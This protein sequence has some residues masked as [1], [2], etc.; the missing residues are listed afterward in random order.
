MPRTTTRGKPKASGIRHRTRSCSSATGKASGTEHVSGRPVGSRIH[1]NGSLAS[2]PLRTRGVLGLLRQRGRRPACRERRLHDDGSHRAACGSRRRRP[3]HRHRARDTSRTGTRS[4]RSIA[5]PVSERARTD[6]ALGLARDLGVPDHRARRSCDRLWFRKDFLRSRA[7]HAHRRRC[8][9]LGGRSATRDADCRRIR[10]PPLL[11]AHELLRWVSLQDHPAPCRPMSRGASAHR[12]PMRGPHAKHMRLSLERQRLR[13]GLSVEAHLAAARVPVEG[14]GGVLLS[15][16]ATLGRRTRDE[17]RAAALEAYWTFQFHRHMALA[18]EHREL[19]RPPLGRS[20]TTRP[21]GSP[22]QSPTPPAES[23]ANEGLECRRTHGAR[24]HPRRKS[25]EPGA[26]T[27]SVAT[28][29]EN[30]S[31]SWLAPK[32]CRSFSST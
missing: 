5:S 2:L 1:P 17:H 25:Q 19:T 26:E 27:T 11:R 10:L 6:V 18:I 21:V 7:A 4:S 14:V 29:D 24:G 13:G 28:A 12:R 32:W 8:H 31:G 15:H 23:G 20:Q 22:R 30:R 3:R 9:L 16:G